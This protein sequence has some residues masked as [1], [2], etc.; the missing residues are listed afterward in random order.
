MPLHLLPIPHRQQQADGDCLA[1]CAAMVLAHLHRDI[2]YDAI[3]H[4]LRIQPYGAPAGN[5]RLLSSQGLA[6]TYSSTD[7]RGLRSLLD[8]GYPVIVFVRTGDLPYWDYETNHAIVVVG[9]DENHIYV[10]DPDRLDAP[11]AVPTGDFELA[12]LE[13]DYAYAV[14]KPA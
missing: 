7:M 9:Y 3:L 8:N 10:N 13:R 6:V 1:A 4:L 14:I 12:W 11:I 2:T 5:I